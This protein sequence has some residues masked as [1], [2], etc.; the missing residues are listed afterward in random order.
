MSNL[1]YW[2]S[3]L[4]CW[5]GEKN[6]VSIASDVQYACEVSAGVEIEKQCANLSRLSI[7][8]PCE[9]YMICCSLLSF[10]FFARQ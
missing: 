9:E 2:R 3:P 8:C 7:S 5:Q 4:G 1:Q 10:G 6:G